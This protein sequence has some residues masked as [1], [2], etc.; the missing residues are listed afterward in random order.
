VIPVLRGSLVIG[1]LALLSLCAFVPS[2]HSRSCGCSCRSA[3]FAVSV[4]ARSCGSRECGP[5]ELGGA[6]RTC[7]QQSSASAIRDCSP[8][9]IRAGSTW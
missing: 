2:T 1:V 7:L 4:L 8:N 6:F 9:S 5:A 3:L